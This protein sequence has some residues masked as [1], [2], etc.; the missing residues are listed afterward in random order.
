MGTRVVRGRRFDDVEARDGSPVLVVSEAFAS[1]FFPAGNAVDSLVRLG[2]VDGLE[3]R[4]VGVAADAVINRI[5]EPSEPYF[6]LPYWSDRF[7]E[8]TFLIESDR[9]AAAL[10]PAVRQALVAIDDRL[11][12]RLMTTMAEFVTFSAG[13]YQATA[14]LASTLGLVGLLLTTLGVYG[15]IGYRTSRRTR[16]IGIRI[17]LG[18]A[19]GRILRLV[20]RE[21]MRVGLL[22]L[23]IGVPLA[24][25]ASRLLVSLLFGIS[26]WNWTSLLTA[27]GVLL[28]AVGLATFVPAW[29]AT[30]VNPSNA[31][32]DT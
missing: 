23:V 31:L 10:A 28:A 13:P 22:G 21:G 32:R 20:L 4:I 5:D 14:A 26:P 16:E 15:V 24:L 19:R 18:A 29:R 7:G 2:G 8:A 30:D 11:D 3:H 25:V 6:Y 17:A 27:G 1:R 9:D 12:P